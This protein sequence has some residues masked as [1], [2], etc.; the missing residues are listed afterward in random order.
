MPDILKLTPLNAALAHGQP[1]MLA[2]QGSVIQF[3]PC[4]GMLID[5]IR[6]LQIL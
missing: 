5:W 3:S 4:T 1:R 2:F 6:R